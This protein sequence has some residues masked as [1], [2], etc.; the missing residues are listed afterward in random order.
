MIRADTVHDAG[1]AVNEDL[2]S[3][4]D[5]IAW[6][7]DGATGLRGERLFEPMGSDAA[8]F[9]S[10]IDEELRRRADATA[11]LPRLVEAALTAVSARLSPSLKPLDD[12][13]QIPTAAIAMARLADSRLDLFLLGD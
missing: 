9:V 1:G 11:P 3:V 10:L 4:G 8:F 5:T 2:V 7:L 12:R 13:A 6:V